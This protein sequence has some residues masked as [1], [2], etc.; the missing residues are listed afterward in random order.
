MDDTK[1]LLFAGGIAEQPYWLIESYE[2]YKSEENKWL[3]ENS[4]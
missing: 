4:K 2:I 1:Q 3:K